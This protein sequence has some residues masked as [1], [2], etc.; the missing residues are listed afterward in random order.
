MPVHFTCPHCGQLLSVGRRK[1]GQAVR[2]AACGGGVTVPEEAIGGVLRS[3]LPTPE[4][5]VATEETGD[6]AELM[7]PPAAPTTVPSS[8]HGPHAWGASVTV[9]RMALYSIGGLIVGVGV[10]AFLLGWSMGNTV[11]MQTQAI[12]SLNERF[13]I[14]GRLTYET[15][16]GRV[17]PDTESVVI[18]LPM[19][20][21]PDEKFTIDAIRPE[22]VPPSAQHPVVQ[23]IR[24]LGGD[25]ARTNRT[26][27][28]SLQVPGSGRYY[29]LMIS[30]HQTRP[31]GQSPTTKEIVELGHY[32][33]QGDQ[34]L[35][36]HEYVWLSEQIAADRQIDRFFS[37]D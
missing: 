17:V 36:Q 25:F 16:R 14:S 6:G 29:V 20:K 3:P 7:A 1:V 11:A 27:D 37:A 24:A 28:Y 21:R 10:V 9:S 32:F 30:S 33:R 22:A 8:E 2:C 15:S 35:G 5:P 26:G 12:K 23:G 34:L 31:S 19:D 18:V 4:E 13:Q